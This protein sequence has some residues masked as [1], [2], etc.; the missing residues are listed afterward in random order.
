MPPLADKTPAQPGTLYVVATPIGTLEHITLR[1]IRI[2]A[3]ADVILAEDTRTTRGLLTHH[4]IR[5]PLVSLHGHNEN[6]RAKQV[7]EWLREGRRLAL[8]SEAGTP[9]V[10]DPGAAI[11]SAV[12]DAGLPVSPVPGSSALTA[13]VSVSGFATLPV[14]FGGFFPRKPGHQRR[15]CDRMRR[16]TGTYVFFES[17]YRVKSTL[18][19]LS[20]HTPDMAVCLVR[21][22]TK[23]HETIVRGRP[24]DLAAR[25][26]ESEPRGEFVL[27]LHHPR[28]PARPE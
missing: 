14:V 15:V 28:R 8:V 22:A 27:L 10:S 5:S 1:A 7:L 16:D 9:G 19:A 3:E 24:A 2:L 17:P 20:T 12:L 23:I 11:V 25:L 13:A 26:T 21:E 4:A 6:R 18:E